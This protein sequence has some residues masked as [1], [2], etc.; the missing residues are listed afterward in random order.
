MDPSD[1]KALL[2][3]R[4]PQR[5]STWFSTEGSNREKAPAVIDRFSDLEGLETDFRSSGDTL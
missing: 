3:V 5:W 2:G 1:D 4:P